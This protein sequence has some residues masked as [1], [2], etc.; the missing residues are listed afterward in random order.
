MFMIIASVAISGMMG[1]LFF[2]RTALVI[3]L[4][5]SCF[6]IAFDHPK[7]ITY[8]IDADVLVLRRKGATERIPL[9]EINDSTLLD[10]RAARSV[11][12]EKMRSATGSGASKAELL[13]MRN[14]FTR[15]C[16]VDI[17]MKSYTFNIGR[18][19]IDNRPDA[20][21]D[22]ILLRLSTGRMMLL[23]PLYN[24]DM[25]VSLNRT[26]HLAEQDRRRA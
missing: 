17:G 25:V 8:M 5:G 26:S 14:A 15:W 6:S 21:H 4:V 2:F 19:L 20:K 18:D 24:Q 11:I 16:T 9:S 10:R 12:Q 22:L 3:W 13:E 23:S 7:V 1:N